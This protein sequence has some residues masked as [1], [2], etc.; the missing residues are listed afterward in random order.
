[1]RDTPDRSHSESFQN[2]LPTEV[3]C[4]GAPPAASVDEVTRTILLSSQAHWS[5]PLLSLLSHRQHRT[6][7]SAFA[8]AAGQQQPLPRPSENGRIATASL[9]RVLHMA[10]GSTDTRARQRCL[11]TV[12]K[13]PH[14]CYL[15]TF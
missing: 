15:T 10:P 5:V 8:A 2:R 12:C 13:I 6:C 11:M 4:T 14:Q 7:S 1:S 9:I 3:L